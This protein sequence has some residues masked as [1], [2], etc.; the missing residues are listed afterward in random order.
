MNT[1]K[2]VQN[3]LK[4]KTKDLQELEST[5]L[6]ID[7]QISAARGAISALE[8]VMKHFP[9]E[10]GGGDPARSLRAGGQVHRIYIILKEYGK[11]MHIKE[12]LEK[13]GKD[14]DNKTQQATGSQLNSYVRQGKIFSRDM[15]NT[16]GLKEWRG[17]TNNSPTSP[18]DMRPTLTLADENSLNQA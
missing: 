5:R 4:R 14:T 11:P 8:E 3:Q 6:A 18:E 10:D 1:P 12:I 2:K 16:F 9:K 15:P 13:L 7:I 17:S